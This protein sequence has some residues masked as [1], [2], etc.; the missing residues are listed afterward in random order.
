M[1]CPTCG[2]QRAM[3]AYCWNCGNPLPEI[4]IED[5]LRFDIRRTRKEKRYGSSVTVNGV[6]QGKKG[7]GGSK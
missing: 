4:T 5:F 1:S 6:L 2:S 7:V 3:N